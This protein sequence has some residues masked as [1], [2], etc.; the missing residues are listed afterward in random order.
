MGVRIL[1]ADYEE[2]ALL[3][4]WA[5]QAQAAIRSEL[6][7]RWSQSYNI[8]KNSIYSTINLSWIHLRNQACMPRPRLTQS[9]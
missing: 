1:E 8:I 4:E 9:Q 7:E 6:S 3:A 5:E 2:M